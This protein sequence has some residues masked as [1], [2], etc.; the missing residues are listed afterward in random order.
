MKS[1]VARARLLQIQT[2]IGNLCGSHVATWNAAMLLSNDLQEA[3]MANTGKRS[4]VF[5]D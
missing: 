1:F 4:P 5:K 3:M 2:G